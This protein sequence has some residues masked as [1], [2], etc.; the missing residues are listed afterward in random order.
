MTIPFLWIAAALGLGIVLARG[1]V[2]PPA[3]WLGG[4]LVTLLLGFVLC[5]RARLKEAWA[6]GLVCCSFTGALAAALEPLALPANHVSR[7]AKAGALPDDIALRWRGRLRSDPLRLPWGTRYEIALE[8]VEIGG[9]VRAISGG[10]RASYF[11]NSQD[12]EPAPLL[13]AGDRAEALTRARVP[14]NFLNPGAFD[15]KAHMARE[16][17]D[18]TASLRSTELLRKL[19][20]TRPSFA[21]RLARLRGSMLEQLDRL[22]SQQPEHAAVLRAMLLGD[23]SFIDHQ[24]AEQFQ[25][26]AAYHVLV[27]SGM[28]VTVLALCTFWLGRRL[29][30]PRWA[31]IVITGAVLAAFLGVVEDKPPILRAALMAAVVLIAAVFFRRALL[32]NAIALSASLILMAQPSALAD[33]SFQLSFLAAG[34][35]GALGLPWIDGT[36]GPYRRA[37]AHLTDPAR[38]PAHAPRVAQFRLDVRDAAAWL[39][40][41][42]PGRDGASR[43]S[44]VMLAGAASAGLRLWE[45]VV[46]SA[47]IQLGMLPIMALYFHRVSAGGVAANIPASLVS[48]AIVPAGFLTMACAAVWDWAGDLAAALTGALASLLLASVEWFSGM[49]W[50]TWRVPNPPVWLLAAHMLG[51]IGLAVCLRAKRR[52]L[53]WLAGAALAATS[54]LVSLHPFAPQLAPGRLE[55]TTLD[56]GQGD[57]IFAAFPGG[58]TLLIDG[59]G[60][61]GAVRAG[62]FRTG[63][64]IGEQVVSPYLW[65]RGIQRIDAVALT[66]AHQDHL[67]GL[68][69]VLENFSVNELWIARDVDS[70][71]GRT[72][73][74]T[75]ARRGVRV[76]RKRRGHWF[77]WGDASGLFLWP[78]AAESGST[79]SAARNDDS[80]VLRLDYGRTSLL[81]A[82]DIERDVEAELVAWGDP[83]DTDFLKVPHHGSRTSATANFLA[84][85]TP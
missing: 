1:L 41:R 10:L 13:R 30:F 58:Q 18:L 80:M 36:S 42:L 24:R 56:V 35:I 52:A 38:D 40:A 20:D 2:L 7:L 21:H 28:H 63:L 66:H 44:R 37:L 76:V 49:E 43:A 31:V 23:R 32:L 85:I 17:I 22:F 83:L 34:M 48:A 9:Q 61:F 75:A 12:T 55:V 57:A 39:A 46:V 45:V 70:A 79:P 33:P 50:S 82:G 59:G 25:R 8:E 6:A 16:G 65:S 15:A 26:T 69:A 73:L 53:A 47:S 64:D 60:L 19:G 72:L 77:N 62:G 51:I 5:R 54:V 67:D 29:G 74:E 81:L 68:Q 11:R 84:A 3:L 71:A 78:H 4:A 14:R 27:I